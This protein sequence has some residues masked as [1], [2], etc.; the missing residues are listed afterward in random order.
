MRHYEWHELRLLG[1]IGKGGMAEVYEAVLA[2]TG[3]HVAVKKTAGASATLEEEVV[4]RLNRE[5]DALCQLSHPN[6][7]RILGKGKDEQGHPFLVMELIHGTSLEEMLKH[8]GPLPESRAL[9][10]LEPLVEAVAHMHSRGVIHRDIKPSN[11]LLR[12][13]GKHPILIDFGLARIHDA[14]TITA[15]ASMIG[16][17]QYASPEALAGERCD[18]RSDVYQLGLLLY[19]MCTGGLMP[20]GD[21]LDEV[22]KRV[23]SR[24]LAGRVSRSR[25]SAP[26]RRVVGECTRLERSLRPRDAAEMRT[27]LREAAAELLESELRNIPS[28]EGSEAGGTNEAWPMGDAARR[29]TAAAALFISLLLVSGAFLWKYHSTHIKV[30]YSELYRECLQDRRAAAGAEHWRALAEAFRK[31]FEEER[32][33]ADHLFHTYGLLKRA[34]IDPGGEARPLY[35]VLA[36]CLERWITSEARRSGVKKA[37]V[38]LREEDQGHSQWWK[39]LWKLNSRLKSLAD[40]RD[41]GSLERAA[42][43]ISSG[44][45]AS[46]K[47]DSSPSKTGGPP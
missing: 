4:S 19:V 12:N 35:E 18:E 20:F 29:R 25:L 38:R 23:K 10:L 30:R 37:A 24:W 33:G 45:P 28:A 42:R 46:S 41:E 36:E 21:D 15:R 7:V 43:T 9:S 17:I 5:M 16:T 13:N 6:I 40:G 44:T 32:I 26:L 8:E 1:R 31:A 47:A 3:E 22:L 14:T 2:D 34:R 11:I 27:L 39:E